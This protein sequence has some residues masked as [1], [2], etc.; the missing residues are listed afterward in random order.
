MEINECK[1]V[2]TGGA[3]GMG[4]ATARKLRT[5][6]AHVAIIDM[7]KAAAEKISKEIDKIFWIK[8]EWLMAEK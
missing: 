2:V 1:A 7:N 3:S 5:K 6:G 4:A 8:K